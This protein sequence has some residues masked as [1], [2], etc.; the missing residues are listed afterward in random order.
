MLKKLRLFLISAPVVLALN[1]L[2]NPGVFDP[3]SFGAVR[4]QTPP[5]IQI[6]SRDIKLLWALNRQ[7]A[8]G[9]ARIQ[10]RYEPNF[11]RRYIKGKKKYAH[12]EARYGARAIASSYGPWQIMYLTAHE[13]GYRGRPEELAN[14]ETS[15]P[16]VVKYLDFL[17]KKLNNND[18]A[19]I[20]AYNAGPG[21]VGTNPAYTSRVI[22]FL[23]KAPSDWQVHGTS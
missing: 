21:G 3:G 9:K 5:R 18:R 6:Q 16:Y 20:S 22:A 23:K 13:M 2:L 11:Y 1:Q 15:L 17:R 8:S 4:I 19:V 12:L 10:S 7:E 14:A